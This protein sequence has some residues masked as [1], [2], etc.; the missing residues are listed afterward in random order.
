[1]PRN[2]EEDTIPVIFALPLTPTLT[3]SPHSAPSPATC[4]CFTNEGQMLL[5][6]AERTE[7]TGAIDALCDEKGQ[8]HAP[9]PFVIIPEH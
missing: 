9:P 3:H 1:M 8:A 4:G 2:G 7:P 6:P 5:A